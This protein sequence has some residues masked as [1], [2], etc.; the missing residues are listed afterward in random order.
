MR[1]AFREKINREYKEIEKEI[2]RK[3]KVKMPF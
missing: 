2:E 3:N 1:V